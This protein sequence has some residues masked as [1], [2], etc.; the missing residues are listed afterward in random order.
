MSA[1]SGRQHHWGR[2]RS[3]FRKRLLAVLVL[4]FLAGSC[5]TATAVGCPE[6][7]P[8]ADVFAT[9]VYVGVERYRGGLTT[10]AQA[11]AMIGQSIDV[12]A[13]VFRLGDTE[14]PQPRYE[15]ECHPARPEEG[16]VPVDR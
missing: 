10:E 14:I 8:V 1:G 3:L 6:I 15:I 12:S 5:T 11:N 9:Y 7:R 4:P 16:E 2:S 13:D